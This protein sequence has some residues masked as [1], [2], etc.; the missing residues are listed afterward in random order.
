MTLQ[1]RSYLHGTDKDTK[2][3]SKCPTPRAESHSELVVFSFPRAAVLK[4]LGWV[5][6]ATEMYGRTVL[7]ARSP[8]KYPQGRFLLRT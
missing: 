5:P 7:G 4:L 6:Q 8:T 3:K 1:G 2:I